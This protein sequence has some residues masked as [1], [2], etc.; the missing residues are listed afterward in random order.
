MT[1]SR[2]GLV[3]VKLQTREHAM[4]RARQ[5][6]QPH[7]TIFTW[8]PGPAPIKPIA[9]QIPYNQLGTAQNW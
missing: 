8:L 9:V 3:Q 4:H 6:E 5:G 7:S 2:A 1:N